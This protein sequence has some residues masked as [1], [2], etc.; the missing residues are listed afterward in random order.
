LGTKLILDLPQV[1]FSSDKWTSDCFL[2]HQ[3][4]VYFF[5][6]YQH[7]MLFSRPWLLNPNE[8]KNRLSEKL[9]QVFFWILCLNKA[10]MLGHTKNNYNPAKTLYIL[11]QVE[12]TF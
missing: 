8:K 1:I 9:Q 5:Y 7:N 10:G 3:K 12:T 4:A 2:L 11:T 6:Q